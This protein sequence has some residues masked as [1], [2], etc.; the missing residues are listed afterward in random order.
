MVIDF[1][2]IKS[3]KYLPVVVLLLLL[4]I[5]AGVQSIHP[6]ILLINF[7]YTV[8]I[9]IMYFTIEN[10]DVKIL[11]EVYKN[12]K[13]LENSNNDMSNYLFKISQDLKKPTDKLLNLYS[14]YKNE[15]DKITYNIVK[16]I[17]YVL[18]NSLAFSGM[19]NNKI[20]LYD[21]KYNIINI[22]NEL[23][24]RVESKKNS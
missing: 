23:K 6:E 8:T 12:R 3:R 5:S 24:N 21:T 11:E 7:I 13:L 18:D 9:F 20:K 10:P 19:K 2:H 22:F 4:I 15:K 17:V 16:E 1:K 14:D